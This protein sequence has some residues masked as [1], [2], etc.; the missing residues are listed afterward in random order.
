MRKTFYNL[1][2]LGRAMSACNRRYLAYLEHFLFNLS[3][4]MV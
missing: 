1:I 2:A 3:Q 4:D